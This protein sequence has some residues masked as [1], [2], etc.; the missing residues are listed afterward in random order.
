MTVVTTRPN[1]TV[2]A[3]GFANSGGAGRAGATSDDD[4]G[5]YLLGDTIAS[6]LLMGFAEPSIPAGALVKGVAA[7]L[8]VAKTSGD[9]A[10]RVWLYT[11][12]AGGAHLAMGTIAPAN[13]PT[14]ITAIP[15]AAWSTTPTNLN[16]ALFQLTAGE[17]NVYEMYVDTVYVAK[18]VTAPIAPTG[19]I[20]TTNVPTVE[21]ANTLDSDG[22]SQTH[23]QVRLFTAAQYGAGGFDPATSAATDD[24]GIAQLPTVTSWTPDTPLAGINYRAYVRVAQTVNGA[25]HWSDWAYTAFAVDVDVPAVPTLS[26]TADDAAACI[27]IDV[28]GNTGDETTDVIQLARSVDGGATWLPVLNPETPQ[29]IVTG[30]DTVQFDFEAPNGTLMSYRARAGHDFEGEYAWS[31]WTSPVTASW[32]S[33]TWWL[34]CPEHPTLNTVVV[35]DSLPSYQRPAR[36]GTFQPLGSPSTVV[37]SDRRGAARGTLRLQLDTAAEQDAVDALLDTGATLLLQGPPAHHWTDRYVRFGDQDRA[38]WIDKAWIGEVI[39][40]LAWWEVERPGGVVAAWPE[41]GS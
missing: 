8:R 11:D 36:H 4:G 3:S 5:T 29:G 32:Q 30:P 39:D 24:S 23:F 20:T 35:P 7:R 9:A 21:W 28:E 14:T 12:A 10:V 33:S 40:T 22:G 1:A 25:Q 17:I 31:A 26:V 18:P 2:S 37:V 27:E 41:G 13:S 34:K 15:A 6:S 19:T 38:R 16:V